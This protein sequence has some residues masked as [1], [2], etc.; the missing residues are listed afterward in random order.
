MVPK[1]TQA[2]IKI[3]TKTTSGRKSGFSFWCRKTNSLRGFSGLRGFHFRDLTRSQIDEKTMSEFDSGFRSCFSALS[4]FWSPF[5]SYFAPQEFPKIL[6]RAIWLPFWRQLA[7]KT[8][9]L[10]RKGTY[11]KQSATFGV[12]HCCFLLFLIQ[13]RQKYHCDIRMYHTC[14][15]KLYFQFFDN[16]FLEVDFSLIATKDFSL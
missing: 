5:W 15:L 2:S 3:D 7:H 4:S 11:S 8:T 13:Q 16:E 6:P 1:K 12:K 9:L 14:H 10:M